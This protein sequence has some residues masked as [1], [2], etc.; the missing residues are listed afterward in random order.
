MADLTSKYEI[1]WILETMQMCNKEKI[2]SK[3]TD[4]SRYIFGIKKK[5]KNKEKI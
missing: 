5:T 1:I 3:N 2:I 4:N